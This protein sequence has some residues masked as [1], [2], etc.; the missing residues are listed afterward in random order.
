MGGSNATAC[1]MTWSMYYNWKIV[2]LNTF[3]TFLYLTDDIENG[4]TG[5]T[6]I[7]SVKNRDRDFIRLALLH[8]DMTRE[9][10][11]SA[12]EIQ[13]I[14]SHLNTNVPEFRKVLDAQLAYHTGATMVGNSGSSMKTIPV[15][16][17]TSDISNMVSKCKVVDLKRISTADEITALS[18]KPDDVLY[19]R[20]KVS[21]SATLILSGKVIILAG[22]DGFR[23]EIGPWSVLGMGALY[24]DS[25][26]NPKSDH[27]AQ[28]VPDFTAFIASDSV[29]CVRITLANILPMFRKVSVL[30][31][32]HGWL[33]LIVSFLILCLSSM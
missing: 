29:R 27:P 20:G 13:A 7:V 1:N 26:I 14:V 16:I 19:T 22:Q 12:D 15:S 10:K 11:L 24:G 6:T 23:S 9:A 8:G 4:P 17:T 32:I 3:V 25:K 30:N 21:A 31:S 28:Y 2:I 5:K 33:C 18:P